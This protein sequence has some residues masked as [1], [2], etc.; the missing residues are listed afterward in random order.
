MRTQTQTAASAVEFYLDKGDNKRRSPG[1]KNNRNTHSPKFSRKP[2][3]TR[4]EQGVQKVTGREIIQG[5]RE[6]PGVRQRE[7]A[8]QSAKR[9]NP[10]SRAEMAT[11][12]CAAEWPGMRCRWGRLGRFPQRLAPS[13]GGKV[14]QILVRSRE[15]D[16][17]GIFREMTCV[18]CIFT[19]ILYFV[20]ILTGSIGSLWQW[21]EKLTQMANLFLIYR[22]KLVC[23]V[24]TYQFKFTHL[25]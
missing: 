23:F 4:E 15:Q 12:R 11:D 20:N 18:R 17:Q 22:K 24:Q 13:R 9:S 21:P 6:S 3:T 8:K 7:Q 16:V 14:C 25:T 2:L 5:R 1:G 19:H 10:W